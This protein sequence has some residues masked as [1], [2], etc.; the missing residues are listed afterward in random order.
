MIKKSIFY[1]QTLLYPLS[2]GVIT[3]TPGTLL[4]IMTALSVCQYA[5]RESK[6]ALRFRVR[7]ALF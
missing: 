5:D 6:N 1:D 7:R 2:S 3:L 4:L